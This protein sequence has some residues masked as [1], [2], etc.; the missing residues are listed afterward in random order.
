MRSNVSWLLLLIGI[1]KWNI[2]AFSN[3]KLGRSRICSVL[4]DHEGKFLCIFS[5]SAGNIE[6]NEAEVLAIQKAM[7]LS[8][9]LFLSFYKLIGY[10]VKFLPCY[11][12]D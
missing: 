7:L 5:C 8:I 4:K 11:Y 9:I 10:G 2:D 6:S 3:G 12:L 1:L